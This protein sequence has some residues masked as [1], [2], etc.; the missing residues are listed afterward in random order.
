MTANT[1]SQACPQPQKEVTDEFL[2]R[3]HM[4]DK[5]VCS[6]IACQYTHSLFPRHGAVATPSLTPSR[7]PACRFR[8]VVK[9]PSQHHHSSFK[10]G[11]CARPLPSER[12][13]KARINTH[14]VCPTTRA[15]QGGCQA[16]KTP[17]FYTPRTREALL[18]G[19]IPTNAT[20]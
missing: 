19:P 15:E 17:P 3:Q 12:E 6:V 9:V 8:N 14:L 13:A 4:R 2:F 11:T 10:K 20:A 16:R 5:S 7:L 18:A 1:P